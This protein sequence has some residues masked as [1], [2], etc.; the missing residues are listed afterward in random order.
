M[1]TPGPANSDEGQ[2]LLREFRDDDLAGYD[3]LQYRLARVLVDNFL[4]QVRL[5]EAPIIHGCFL[6]SV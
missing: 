3:R 5:S 4:G 2:A 6:P 1:I